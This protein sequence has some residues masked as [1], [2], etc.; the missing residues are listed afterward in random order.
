MV[1]N[2]PFWKTITRSSKPVS[3]GL[4]V[5]LLA[6]GIAWENKTMRHQA[7]ETF[8]TLAIT[9]LST[10]GIKLI[11]NRQRPYEKYTG[12]Y[13]DI[14]QNGKSFVSGHTSLAFGTATTLSIIYKKWYV[15]VPAYAW[16]SSVAYSRLYFGQHYPTDLMGAAVVGAGS[17][18]L[19]HK[20][21]KWLQRHKQNKV[22]PTPTL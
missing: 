18:W 4:P 17:A 3:Y 10:Q 8:G 13:P 6:A 16:A 9:A 1:P 22:N 21:N 11:A 7:L 14:Y 2:S 5:V 19:S 15:V 12:I 20:A